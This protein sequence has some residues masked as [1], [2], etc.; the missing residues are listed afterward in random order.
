MAGFIR[1]GDARQ[2]FQ[3]KTNGI[4]FLI[5]QMAAPFTFELSA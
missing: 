5:L 3:D 4:D 1:F 2:P